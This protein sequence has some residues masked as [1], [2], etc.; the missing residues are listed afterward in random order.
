MYSIFIPNQPGRRWMERNIKTG[1]QA[2]FTI[3]E[4]MIVMTIIAILA[5]IAIPMYQLTLLRAKEAVLMDNQRTINEVIDQYITRGIYS[6]IPREV[7]WNLNTTGT[8]L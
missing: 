8:S 4:L 1:S 6:L 3:L 5:A 7:I 2:G